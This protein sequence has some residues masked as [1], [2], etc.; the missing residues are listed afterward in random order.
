MMVESLTPKFAPCKGSSAIE[1][2]RGRHGRAV[3]CRSGFRALG[4]LD[5]HMR[6]AKLAHFVLMGIGV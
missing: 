6:A 5:S 1:L 2:S 4:F 3:D